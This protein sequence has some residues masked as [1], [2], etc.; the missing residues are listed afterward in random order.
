[1]KFFSETFRTG[2]RY[3]LSKDTSD[4]QE[5][6]YENIEQFGKEKDIEITEAIENN[7]KDFSNQAVEKY[8]KYISLSFIQYY[9][10]I[11]SK[12]EKPLIVALG[13]C[14]LFSLVI[15][16]ILIKS[17]YYDRCAKDYFSYSFVT[18]AILTAIYPIYS[19][20]TGLCK[21]INITPKY[22]YDIIKALLLNVQNTFLYFQ[23]YCLLSGLFFPLQLFSALMA[24]KGRMKKMNYKQLRDMSVYLFIVLLVS[25]CVFFT[26]QEKGKQVEQLPTDKT[27]FLSEK[28]ENST[29]KTNSKTE[30]TENNHKKNETNSKKK[31]NQPQIKIF[32]Q[33]IV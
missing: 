25:F 8:R 24:A 9:S 1:M 13:V 31:M 3:D 27:E 17:K 32:L 29:T 30:I 33:T 15:S 20:S 21:K 14:L 26:T 28:G 23:L 19:L 18:A 2:K 5:K 11:C 6:L 7:I 4:I 16:I 10:K 22:V 12:F